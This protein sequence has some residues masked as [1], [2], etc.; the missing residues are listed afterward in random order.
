MKKLLAI[1][2]GT[3]LFVALLNFLSQRGP[4]PGAAALDA[5]A[6]ASAR[7]F[8]TEVSRV[9]PSRPDWDHIEGDVADGDNYRVVLF[10]RDMP[11]SKWQVE[12]DSKAVVRG[13][14]KVLSAQGRQP[15]QEHLSIT[16][17]AHRREAGETGKA[18]Q[19]VF[20]RAVYQWTTDS[21]VY[22]PE[23]N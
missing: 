13:M 19:R 12:R 14:L 7:A 16:A 11:T 8:A 5:K 1:V 3:I 10:Y 23:A 20:G 15:A 2:F 9:V 21:I 4:S 6:Q 22:K 18:L 17:R